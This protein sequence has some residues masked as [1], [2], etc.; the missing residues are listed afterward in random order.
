MAGVKKIYE[1]TP[2]GLNVPVGA[3]QD[4][5]FRALS[6]HGPYMAVGTSINATAGAFDPEFKALEPA[7]LR[8]TGERN[9]DTDDNRRSTVAGATNRVVGLRIPL[10]HPTPSV[11]VEVESATPF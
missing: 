1:V 10:D 6:I 2:A 11:F 3:G 8:G 7:K 4:Y 9:G 5:H